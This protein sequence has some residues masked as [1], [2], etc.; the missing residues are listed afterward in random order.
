MTVKDLKEKIKD[1]PDNMLVGMTGYFGEYLELNFCET[2]IAHTNFYCENPEE[3]KIE[4]LELDFDPKG[5]E[6]D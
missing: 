2:R 5:D 6:P 1:L 3:T 4:I